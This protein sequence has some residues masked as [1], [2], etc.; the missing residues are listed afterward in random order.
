[1]ESRIRV[2]LDDHLDKLRLAGRDDKDAVRDVHRSQRL[3]RLASEREFALAAWPELSRHFASGPD[4]EPAAIRPRLEL[5]EAGTWQARLFR[6]AALTWSVPVSRGYGRRMRFLVWDEQNEKLIG[7]IGLTDPVFNLGARDSFI[8]WTGKQRRSRLVCIMDAY[9]LG[10]IP[11]YNMLLGGKLVACLLKTREIRDCFSHRYRDRSGQISKRKKHPRLV[12]VTTSS[13]LGR[14]SVYNRLKLQG[15][16][17]L[18]SVGYTLGW[19]HFHVPDPVFDLMRG[20][21]RRRRHAYAQNHQFGDGPNWR[22]RVIRQTLVKLGLSPSLLRHGIRREV[23]VCEL[24]TN[25]KAVLR[26]TA[27][28]PRYTGL[29]TVSEVTG[30]ALERW[31]LPRAT[32]YPEFRSWRSQDLAMMVMPTPVAALPVEVA[33]VAAG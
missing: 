16:P 14:S 29:P 31:I 26:G 22:M 18:I 15:R 11:P 7:L 13:A 24:A 6:L 25:A 12:M 2:A 3:D 4:V 27:R 28:I 19:G 10:A 9:V 8:G 30:M 33:E 20:Y 17:F 32:R 1:M 23:F 5:I 21:L